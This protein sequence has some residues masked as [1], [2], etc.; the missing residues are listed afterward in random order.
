MQTLF[1]DRNHIVVYKL[2]IRKTNVLRTLKA[3]M[4]LYLTRPGP[5]YDSK[6]RRT[7]WSGEIVVQNMTDG[8]SRILH[9]CAIHVLYYYALSVILKYRFYYVYL[10]NLC[11]DTTNAFTR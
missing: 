2:L 3:S 7:R 9:N 4:F 11:V 8:D 1:C 10:I 5:K 6:C